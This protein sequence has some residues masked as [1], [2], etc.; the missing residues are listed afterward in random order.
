MGL[1]ITGIGA[2]SDLATT[3][4]N[5]IWPDKSEQE[6]QELAAA[7]MMVQGQL[8]TNKAEATNSNILVSG[9]RPFIGWICGISLAL[10]YIPK[11][12]V[13]TVIWSYQ[14][15]VIVSAWNGIG[16]PT[17]PPFPDIGVTDVLGLLGGMLGLGGM[18]SWEKSKGVAR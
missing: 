13:M 10:V 2:I 8:D 1:D 12:L 17:V 3:V 4:I 6:K 11:A 15:W 9:W 7:V 14:A 16:S 18:R 5:K